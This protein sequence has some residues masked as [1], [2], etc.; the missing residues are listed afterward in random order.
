M[1]DQTV[2]PRP[3]NRGTIGQVLLDEDYEGRDSLELADI[4]LKYFDV[5]WKPEPKSE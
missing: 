5:T 3:A 2:T 4:I 1:S